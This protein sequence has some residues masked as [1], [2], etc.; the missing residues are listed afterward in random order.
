VVVKATSP[1][2]GPPAAEARVLRFTETGGLATDETVIV[3]DLPVGDI[4][5][6]GELAFDAQG[7]LLVTVGDVQDP[8]LAQ[9]PT[10]MAGKVLRYTA[11]GAIPPDNPDPASPVLCSGLRNPFALAVHPQSGGLYAADNG[12]TE[13][14]ELLLLVPGKNYGWGYEGDGL[15]FAEGITIRTWREVIVP[16]ALAFHPGA[17]GWEAHA[18]ELFLTTYVEEDLRRIVLLGADVTDFHQELPFLSF[19]PMANA[20]KPLDLLVA[21]DGSLYIST[22]TAIQRVF[23]L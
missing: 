17:P 5:D 23:A 8:D 19:A 12:P 11:A 16:T 15:G 1:A 4:N 2:A 14:D 20:N 3:D 22:F 9:D 10:S 7:R 18:G 13:D 21:P 6:G